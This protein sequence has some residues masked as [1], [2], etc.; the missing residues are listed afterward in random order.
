MQ[1]IILVFLGG[2]FGSL[3]RYGISHLFIT[4]WQNKFSAT[5]ATLTSNI[6]AT[7]VLALVWYAIDLGKLPQNT[8][9][10]VLVGF[11]GGFSTFSTFSF[12]TF[13]LLREGLL[14]MALLNVG[15]SVVLCLITLFLVF[16]MVS[17]T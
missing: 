16:K 17:P 6:L 13:Q 2:G 7:L 8:K 4:Q 12:E 10:L 15:I 1:N 14:G 9:F 3:A 5:T 11:C